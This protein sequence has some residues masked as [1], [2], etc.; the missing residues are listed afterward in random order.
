VWSTSSRMAWNL[1][2]G[3]VGSKPVADSAMAKK[4]PR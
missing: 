2:W 3:V 4:S 1:R